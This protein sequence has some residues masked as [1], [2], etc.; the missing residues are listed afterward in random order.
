ML[1]NLLLDKT[2]IWLVF[3]L[4]H[5][6]V[7]RRRV[8]SVDITALRALARHHVLRE[9]R[10]YL[11][12]IVSSRQLVS[13]VDVAA[14]SWSWTPSPNMI[15]LACLLPISVYL[16]GKTLHI[17]IIILPICS[18]LWMGPTATKLLLID[19]A[20]RMD[21]ELHLRVW[22]TLVEVCGGA[23]H[24]WR[25]SE[26]SL[27]WLNTNGTIHLIVLSKFVSLHLILVLLYT[28]VLFDEVLLVHGILV[29]L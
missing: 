16:R 3:I 10:V 5:I 14:G 18:T 15:V 2:A 17:L 20:V 12:Q 6:S 29:D 23:C 22:M 26:Y 8:R 21:F 19:L 27:L 11:I 24:L 1:L 4:D 28:V 25:I 7:V 9:L 13:Q